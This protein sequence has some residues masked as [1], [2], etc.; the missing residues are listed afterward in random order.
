[1]PT[2]LEFCLYEKD[3]RGRLWRASFADLAE[4]KRHAQELADDEGKE[5]FVHSFKDF[6]EL[7][8]ICPVKPEPSPHRTA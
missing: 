7:A 2:D 5:F 1:M 4:A 6:I 8:R 3:T